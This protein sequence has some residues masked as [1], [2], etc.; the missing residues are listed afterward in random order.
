MKGFETLK[1][2]NH[3]TPLQVAHKALLPYPLIRLAQGTQ[4]VWSGSESG[5][6]CIPHMSACVN[7]G[8]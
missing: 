3:T 5:R 1:W 7:L 4:V 6:M 8:A 2:G